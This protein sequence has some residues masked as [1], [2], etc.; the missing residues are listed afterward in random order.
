V[1]PVHFTPC[2]LEVEFR[3]RPDA[4]QAAMLLGVQQAVEV[5]ARCPLVLGL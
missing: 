1:K 2:V 3:P 4:L 5:E